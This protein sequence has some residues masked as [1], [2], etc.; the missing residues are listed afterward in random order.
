MVRR[1]RAVLCRAVRLAAWSL[2]VGLG[3]AGVAHAQT[4][5]ASQPDE[6]SLE[7]LLRQGL[8]QVPTKVQVSTASRFAQSADLSPA[9]TYV[10]TAEDIRLLGLRSLVD[11]LRSLPGLHTTGNGNFS[12][13]AARGIGRPGDFNSRVLLQ[14]DGIRVNENTTD[15]ALIGPEFFLDVD[16]IERV[17]FTPGPG[18]ALYGNNALLGVINIITLH[19]DKLAGTRIRAAVDSLRTHGVQFSHGRRG[20]DGREFWVSASSSE[21]SRIPLGTEQPERVRQRLLDMNWDRSQRLFTSAS[22]GGLSLRAAVS[23]RQ[24]GFGIPVGLQGEVAQP[25]QARVRYRNAFAALSF[26]HELAPDWELSGNLNMSR[27]ATHVRYPVRT[28]EDPPDRTLLDDTAGRWLNAGLRLGSAYWPGHYVLLGLEY[29]NDYQ[30]EQTQGLEG[31]APFQ[32][33]VGHTR[34]LAWFMQDEWRLGEQQLLVAGVR[35]DRDNRIDDVS[36][37][38]RIAWVWRALPQ[39]NLKLSYGSAYRGI[40]LTEYAY[41]VV[42]EDVQPLPDAER[43]HSWELSWEHSL[44]SRLQ[45]RIALHHSR[46]KGLI[47]Q[48]PDY[49]V[50]VNSGLI[51]QDGVEL[52]LDQRWKDGA[53]LTLSAT[54]QRAT[55]RDAAP[56]PNSP[57]ALLQLHYSRPLWRDDLELG[58]QWLAMSGR[59]SHVGRLPGYGVGNLVLHWRSDA[60]T[61][62]ALGV[63]NLADRAYVDAPDLESG[64]VAQPG[65]S[66]RLSVNWRFGS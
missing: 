27:S 46:L 12:F 21:Q 20:E 23:E 1:T 63:Y 42:R 5:P 8:G 25:G 50:F 13:L 22:W 62:W 56:L 55:E 33:A 47:T 29:Q 40:N 45:Y 26:E 31:E 51:R 2:A 24:R 57:H 61:R 34:R 53:R 32:G 64:R 28:R 52:G 9:L 15:A 59:H 66:V 3:L 6:L 7:D 37:N 48:S 4:T 49:P 41:N 60:Q 16:L 65:R 14:L 30:Q 58:A 35:A 44:S 17:E 10:L 38:P 11:I 36:I 18:S 54:L 39:A 43:V 19:A